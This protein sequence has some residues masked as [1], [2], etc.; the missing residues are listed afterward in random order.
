MCRLLS[1]RTEIFRGSHKANSKQLLPET[2]HGHSRSQRMV[3]RRQPQS[4]PQPIVRSSV[5]KWWHDG[6]DPALNL[7]TRLIILPTVQ[8]KGR[9]DLRSF[10]KDQRCGGLTVDG[11][12]LLIEKFHF[13]SP[14]SERILR[15]HIRVLQKVVSNGQS[16]FRISRQLR[17][18]DHCLQR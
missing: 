11:L 9:L 6:R 12:D 5:R 16:L 10:S 13:L 4:K 18:Q 17:I 2:I 8:H 3:C 1:L 15:L 7:F 14:W